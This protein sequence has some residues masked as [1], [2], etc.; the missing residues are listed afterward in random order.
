MDT[1]FSFSHYCFFLFIVSSLFVCFFNYFVVLHCSPSC[2]L[3]SH[4]LSQLIFIGFIISSFF[5]CVFVILVF[6]FPFRHLHFFFI[7]YYFPPSIVLSYSYPAFLVSLHFFSLFLFHS[8]VPFPCVFLFPFPL[9]VFICFIS[10]VLVIFIF[11]PPLL[12]LFILF[13]FFSDW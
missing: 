4:L 12:S 6:L 9:W 11:F 2:F 10:W 5:Y 1:F 8:S 13:P 7:L 3:F